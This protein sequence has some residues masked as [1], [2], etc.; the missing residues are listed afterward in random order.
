MNNLKKLLRG[1]IFA[2]SMMG[3]NGLLAMEVMQA[4]T[5]D[6]KDSKQ[7]FKPD[8]F[9]WEIMQLSSA[10]IGRIKSSMDALMEADTSNNDCWTIN[11]NS[12]GADFLLERVYH[13]NPILMNL[14]FKTSLH[15]KCVLDVFS[16]HYIEQCYG[17]YFTL[18][19]CAKF[20]EKKVVLL[21]RLF[22]QWH[23]QP[24]ITLK[25]DLKGLKNKF[26]Q[27]RAI[28]ESTTK[29]EKFKNP[30]IHIV[31]YTS[32]NKNTPLYE[33]EKS[34]L[35]EFVKSD[36]IQHLPLTLTLG[37]EMENAGMRDLASLP[38]L[39]QLN[40]GFNGTPYGR[41]WE[42][43]PSGVDDDGLGL[44]TNLHNLAIN[45]N[46]NITNRGLEPLTNLKTLSLGRLNRKFT[47]EGLKILTNLTSLE[48]KSI[49]EKDM[50]GRQFSEDELSKLKKDI[51]NL[52]II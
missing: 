49:Y 28:F 24:K 42:K 39:T 13:D 32:Y 52:K 14:L 23:V 38:N 29:F 33:T 35:L 4:K 19:Q 18:D 6:L 30:N 27:C 44:L 43:L 11:D 15:E 26:D 20:I 12:R 21:D 17:A 40:F 9:Q 51:P 46:V 5:I 47:Y 16:K 2:F 3:M 34:S 36:P 50:V 7:W 37:V 22:N 31:L 25:F 1:I 48:V 10:L 45:Y 41:E 8:S